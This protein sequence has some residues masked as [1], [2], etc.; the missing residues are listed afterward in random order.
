MR[1]PLERSP[2]SPFLHAW[3]SQTIIPFQIRMPY[4]LHTILAIPTVILLACSTCSIYF[5][6][7]KSVIWEIR[8]SVV[9]VI[10]RSF[11]QEMNNQED[12]CFPS[13]WNDK[14]S[15]AGRAQEN[16]VGLQGVVEI[17]PRG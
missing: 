1:A 16:T 13:H 2:V 3:H 11:S 10:Y 4:S 6:A 12:Q 14:A 5:A 9:R 7:L 17:T 15:D 8:D